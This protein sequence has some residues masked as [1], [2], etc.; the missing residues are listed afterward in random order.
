MADE[1]KVEV[2]GGFKAVFLVLGLAVTLF[3]VYWFF[4]TYQDMKNTNVAG[5]NASMNG[6]AALNAPAGL[7][8][9]PTTLNAF[10][11]SK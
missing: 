9:Q 6:G 4:S 10:P 7:V 3:T 2:K 11:P 5:M 1:K 8:P